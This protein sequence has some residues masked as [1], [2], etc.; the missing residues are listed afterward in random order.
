LLTLAGNTQAERVPP[1]H[2]WAYGWR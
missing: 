2:F 1:E